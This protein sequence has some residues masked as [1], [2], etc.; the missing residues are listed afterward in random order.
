MGIEMDPVQ[1]ENV[2]GQHYGRYQVIRKLGSGGMATV[3][4]AQDPSFDRQV[5]LKILPPS[6]L[7]ESDFRQRFDTEAKMIASLEHAAIVPVYDYGEDHGQP[8][9][10]M[11]L[12]TG[13]S[14]ED[15]IMTGRMT[16]REAN[17]VTQRICAALDRAHNSG[18]IHLD[19][20]PANILF[21]RDGDAHLADF[22]IAH[23]VRG[24]QTYAKMGTPLYLSPEQAFGW[25][26]DQRSDVYQMGV[27]I[28]EMLSGTPP[29]ESARPNELVFQHMRAP[30]PK[31]AERGVDLPPRF[32]AVIAR[33]MAKESE[34]RYQSAR[35]LAADFARVTAG[36]PLVLP[37]RPAVEASLG[38]G[39]VWPPRALDKFGQV[40]RDKIPDE[41]IPGPRP[42]KLRAMLWP[43]GALGLI[44]ALAVV[45]VL[46][47]LPGDGQDSPNAT[48]T[49]TLPATATPTAEP[50]DQPDE[51]VTSTQVPSVTPSLAPT[52]V[53]ATAT[54]EPA[55]PSPVPEPSETQLW[56][57]TSARG[58]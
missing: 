16:P 58:D 51:A 35:D 47:L 30:V 1:G 7:D 2:S 15:R 33:A 39:P 38:D 27:V 40:I 18:I 50:T 31:L 36:S 11:Q 49:P 13:G 17:A 3:Y 45:A 5:A 42:S 29:Y 19:L 23:L 6:L 10:V 57:P 20:K 46:I 34:E 8:Y 28:F 4:L 44:L 14:L 12:M 21:D 24:T 52:R 43:W 32:D 56:T 9:L 25:P 48:E 26:V 53:P 22:G 41:P 54:P 55:T 37:H